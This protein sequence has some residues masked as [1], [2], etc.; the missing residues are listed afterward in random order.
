MDVLATEFLLADLSV[1]EKRL[2]RL[3]K[4]VKHGKGAESER[5]MREREFAAL[6]AIQKALADGQPARTVELSKSDEPLLRGYGLLTSKPWLILLNTDDAGVDPDVVAQVR[7][8]WED[9]STRVLSMA[10]RLE[11]DLAELSEEEAIEFLQAWEVAEPALDR[12]IQISYELLDLISFFT[13]GEDEVRAWTIK[14][15]APAVDAAAAIHSDIARAFIRPRSFAAK[16]CW[17]VA[18]W[19]RRASAELFAPRDAPT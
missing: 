7:A 14:R 17:R 9:A 11:M 15:G 12:V 8:R 10:G 3:E 2:E 19:S 5:Q 6:N 13:V 4:E 18:D 1:V 16:T